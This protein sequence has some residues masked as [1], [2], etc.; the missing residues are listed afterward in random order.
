MIKANTKT[1]KNIFIVKKK[2]I[3]VEVYIPNTIEVYIPNTIGKW[4]RI[5]KL[6]Y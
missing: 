6:D 1:N 3:T 2:L 4:E 5:A